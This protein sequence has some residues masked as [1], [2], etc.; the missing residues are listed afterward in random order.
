[1]ARRQRA[2]STISGSRAALRISVVPFA[3]VAAMSAFSV[4]PTETKGNSITAPGARP[5]AVAWT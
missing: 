3:S 5:L 4:A 2:R 1:M